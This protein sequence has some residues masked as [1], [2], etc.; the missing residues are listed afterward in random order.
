MGQHPVRGRHG[1]QV[2]QGSGDGDDHAAGA[3]RSSSM[4]TSTT[5]W[6]GD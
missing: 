6:A 2:E 4:E 5:S 1:D 3:S